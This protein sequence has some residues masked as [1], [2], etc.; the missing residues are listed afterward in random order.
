MSQWKQYREIMR[1]KRAGAGIGDLAVMKFALYAR[2]EPALNERL[3]ALDEPCLDVDL[4]ELRRL[5]RGTVGRS[6]ADFL[7]ER[8]L[9][10]LRVSPELQR[11]HADNLQALRYTTMHDLFHVLTGFPTTPAGELGLFAFMVGQGF[12][13]MSSLRQGELIYGLLMPLHIVGARRNVKAGLALARRAAPLL[14]QR[15]APLLGEPL[16]EVRRRLAIPSPEEAGIVPG[17]ESLLL[18]WLVPAPRP[19]RAA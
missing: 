15:M 6:F 11:R 13:T 16:A 8:G 14:E 10:P 18:R 2:T 12:S 1:A 5:P 3:R 17:H 7:D 4:D 19:A 9:E